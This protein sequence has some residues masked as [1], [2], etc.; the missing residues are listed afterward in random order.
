M[1]QVMYSM[2]SSETTAPLGCLLI[3]SFW[4]PCSEQG[5]IALFDMTYEIDNEYLHG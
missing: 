5:A 1:F 3:L 4:V 2:Y